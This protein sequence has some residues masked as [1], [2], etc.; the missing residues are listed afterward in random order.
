MNTLKNFVL[1]L[2]F[3]LAACASTQVPFTGKAF[4]EVTFL[5]EG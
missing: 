1:V 4:A 3:G 5:V 2:L